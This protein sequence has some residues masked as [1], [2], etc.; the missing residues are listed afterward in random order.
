GDYPAFQNG[1]VRILDADTGR[2]VMQ[3]QGHT[4]LVSDLAFSP[5]GQR[6]ATGSDDRTVRVWDLAS[7]QEVLRLQGHT[8]AVASVRFVSGGRGL[9]RPSPD[10]TVRAWDA[11]PLPEEHTAEGK[12]ERAKAAQES[13]R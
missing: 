4:L 3:L 9:A 1:E 12:G 8:R 6:V 2:E 13:A 7:G 5:D 11:T 10:G